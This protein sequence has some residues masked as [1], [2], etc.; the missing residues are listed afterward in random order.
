M[1][2]GHKYRNK[3]NIINQLIL[4]KIKM[5]LI[6]LGQLIG[7][8]YQICGFVLGGYKIIQTCYLAH[9]W[10]WTSSWSLHSYRLP[11]GLGF[12]ACLFLFKS[13]FFSPFFAAISK[14]CLHPPFSSSCFTFS[15]QPFPSLFLKVCDLSLQLLYM[16]LCYSVW[17]LPQLDA[18][19]FSEAITEKCMLE[20]YLDDVQ[21]IYITANLL[22][23]KKCDTI[24]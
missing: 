8:P 12:P 11:E 2:S 3:L 15:F 4:I 13:L 5:S 7:I 1:G 23:W 14:L 22:S 9:A 6:S 20:I 18:F 24:S 21:A 19:T 17:P 16:G 10:L